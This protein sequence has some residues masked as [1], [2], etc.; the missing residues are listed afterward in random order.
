MMVTRPV[1]HGALA[2]ESASERSR[3][4]GGDDRLTRNSREISARG[5]DDIHR[6]AVLV[7]R[8]RE[9]ESGMRAGNR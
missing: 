5:L 3:G 4:K 6:R 9:G 7:R 8:A 1:C 2:Q